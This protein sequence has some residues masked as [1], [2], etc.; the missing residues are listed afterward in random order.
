LRC[1]DCREPTVDQGCATSVPTEAP[2]TSRRY[3]WAVGMYRIYDGTDE[4]GVVGA[5]A[6]GL[7]AQ[8]GGC[9]R[10]VYENPVGPVTHALLMLEIVW[11]DAWTH[12]RISGPMGIWSN[13]APK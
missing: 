5:V 4:N 8:E 3:R 10:M 11:N 7:V 12:A 9:W 13:Q 1:F 6:P 2:E